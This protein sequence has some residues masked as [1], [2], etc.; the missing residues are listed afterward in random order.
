VTADPDARPVSLRSH[1]RELQRAL[2]DAAGAYFAHR[3]D[4]GCREGQCAEGK[5][6]RAAAGDAQFALSM[7][8]FL[9]EGD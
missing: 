6:L 2:D 7:T 9:N 5:R 3:R 8:R 4:H 1:L